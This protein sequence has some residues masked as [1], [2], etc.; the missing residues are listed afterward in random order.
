MKKL[1]LLLSSIC[2]LNAAIAQTARV[3]VIHNCADLAADSVDVYLIT[4][5]GTSKLLDNFA[6]RTAT[7]FIDAPAGVPLVIG[8]APKTSAS[9]ADTIYSTSVTLTTNVKYVLVA[10]GLVS[11]TGYTPSS[12]VAPF[13]LSVFPMAYEVADTAGRT[14]LL[15]VHGSTDAPMVDVRAGASVLVN[16]ITF[17]NFNSAGYL[18]LPTADYTINVTNS[19]GT[20]QVQRYSAPLATLGLTDSAITVVA[21]GFLDSTVNS[22]GRKFGL[23]VALRMG[24]ALIPLPVISTVSVPT[25]G[26]QANVMI[27]P[28]PAANT[29][30]VTSITG[31][32]TSID[33]LD[34]NGRV[35]TSVS[36]VGKASFNTSALPQGV[37]MVRL[38]DENG[39]VTVKQFTKI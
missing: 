18:R 4:P 31:S 19:T 28:N 11:T 33:L 3:Q 34:L 7:P 13:R 10:N 16:D 39:G 30:N 15:V 9:V 23:W 37:Y 25:V 17:G 20:T 2:G 29:L 14:N 26:E 32:F 38:M 35:I 24:G 8:V 6:F 12:T 27:Y 22:N 5:L 21:S 1:F 36:N